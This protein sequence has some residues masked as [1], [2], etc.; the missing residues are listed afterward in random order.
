MVPAGQEE[1]MGAVAARRHGGRGRRPLAIVVA[2]VLCLPLLASAGP[3]RFKLAMLAPERSAWDTEFRAMDKNLRAATGNEVALRMYAGGVQG[4]E[5]TIV[6]KMRIGQL[7]GGAFLARGINL[8]SR[9]AAIF[10]IPLMFRSE[11]EVDA[12]LATL[13]PYVRD[14]AREKGYEVLGWLRQGFIYCF[15]RDDVRDIAS[16]RH[17]K[18]WVLEEDLFGKTLFRVAGVPAVA[19]QV[20]DVLTGLQSGLIRTVFSPPIGMIALQW[21]TR[22]EYRLDLGLIYSFGA[23]VVN[24]KDWQRIPDGMRTTAEEI[25]G[26]HILT[27]NERLREQNEDAL[28]AMGG[29]IRTV[30]PTA[31]ALSEFRALNE[32]VAGEL[33]G[34]A[35]SEEAFSLLESCLREVR[36]A[37]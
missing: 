26:Q 6:R 16:L 35:F 2:G 13:G 36:T 15:S 5:P 20:A 37:K 11:K 12:A 14:R 7:Q 1:R 28:A 17:A 34:S 29:K 9:D 31:A 18:P 33:R 22:V 10:S 8:I 25:V 32:G 4:D 27:L 30:T 3:I 23:V 21:H 24:R 19:T